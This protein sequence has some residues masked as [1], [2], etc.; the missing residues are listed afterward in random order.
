MRFD[1]SKLRIAVIGDLIL[2]RYLEGAV[3][4][5]SPEA[6]V[7]VLLKRKE[8]DVAGGAANVATNLASLG[9]QVVIS[10]LIGQDDN[11]TRL[12]ELLQRYSNLQTRA[13]VA[14]AERPTTCKTRVLSGLHQLVRIDAESSATASGK[15]ESDLL[16]TVS[17]IVRWCAVVVIS[18]Y[19][20]GVCSDRVIRRT[21][22]AANQLGKVSI[23]DPKRMDFSIY[24]QATLIKPNR[25]EL[26][27]ASRLPCETDREAEQAARVAI[28][29][30]GSSI[31]LSRSE[32][33]MSY[34]GRGGDVIHLPTA[35]REVFDVSGAGDTVV[36]VT[37]LGLGAGFSKAE[38]LRLAN[39]AAGVVVGKIGTAVISREELEAALDEEADEPDFHKGALA[40]LDEAARQRERWRR[41]GL[42]V[43]FTNGCFDLLHP[44]HVALLRQA[45]DACDRLIVAINTDASV[46]RLKGPTRPVQDEGSRACVLGAM[47]AVDLVVL[48]DDDTPLD[49][50]TALK[51]DLL[52]KGAD[53]TEQQVVGADV[54]R[55]SGGQLL[56]VPLIAGQSTSSIVGRTAQTP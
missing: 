52:I 29:Q 35:A 8:R 32:L 3:G 22:E 40:D 44:G 28:E 38:T 13:V 4:R 56:L 30:T 27:D 11:G 33:G 6:P 36:A 54:V 17:D 31:L 55:A 1:F 37:A 42:R 24:S 5:L 16:D 48:F 39:A 20:K 50:I 49:A 21:I 26:S 47:T 53:Y 15:A 12:V 46:K 41:R 19:G 43:G 14:D 23:V 9:A 45:A 34:F 7:A 25:R 18:D 2:D 51:P 10:G